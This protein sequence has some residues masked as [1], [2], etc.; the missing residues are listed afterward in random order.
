MISFNLDNALI[1]A[2]GLINHNYKGTSRKKKK[3]QGRDVM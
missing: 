3:L 1:M 2:Q